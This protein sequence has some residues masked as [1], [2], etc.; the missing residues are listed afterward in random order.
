VPVVRPAQAESTALGAAYLAG[1]GA[2][3]WPNAATLSALWQE[4]RRF[5]PQMRADER[6]ARMA[7]WRRAV[8]RAR[9]WADD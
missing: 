3:L 2:G 4:Q 5:T 9:D 1:L 7:R 8:E 6:A